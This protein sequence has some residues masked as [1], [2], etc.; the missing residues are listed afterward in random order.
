MAEQETIKVNLQHDVQV[1]GIKYPKG[2]GVSVPKNQADDI[3]RI[4]FDHTAYERN[5]HISRKNIVNAG[6]ISVGSGAE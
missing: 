2:T 6:T 5:L 3:M 1:N 4:D